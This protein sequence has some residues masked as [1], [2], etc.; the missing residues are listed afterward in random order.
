MAQF[1]VD[2]RRSPQCVVPRPIVSGV[3]VKPIMLIGQAPGL[4]EYETGKPFQGDAGKGI[5]T[6]FEE[7][8]IPRLHFDE[9]VYSSAVVKC[10]PGSKAKL[11][12]GKVREDV[13]PSAQM[14]RNCQ[15]FFEDQITL[16]DPQIIVTLG[17]LPLKTYLKMTDRKTNMV[18]LENFVGTK[19]QWN[20]RTVIFFPHTSGASRWLNSSENR[21]VFQKAKDL[22]NAEIPLILK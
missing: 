10:F 2:P 15:S 18:K 5:R 12:A 20:G 11:R 4:T 3:R 22:L 21:Q 14:I 7:V 13:F 1:P 16:A 8:G 19:E 6:I 17:G 9:L